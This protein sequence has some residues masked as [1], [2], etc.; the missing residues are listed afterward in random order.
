[1]PDVRV[2]SLPLNPT[3][4]KQN[5]GFDYIEPSV[6]VRILDHAFGKDR[7]SFEIINQWTDAIGDYD[8]MFNVHGRLT[9]YFEALDASELRILVPRTRDYIATTTFR[10]IIS[11]AGQGKLLSEIKHADLGKKDAAGNIWKSTTTDCFKKCAS[12]FGVALE[13]YGKDATAKAF[14]FTFTLSQQNKLKELEERGLKTDALKDELARMAGLG[15]SF[16]DVHPYN[17][18]EFYNYADARLPKKTT[19]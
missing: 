2:L 16:D 19:E 1:M 10:N 8:I 3:A 6:A 5:Q 4:I 15:L 11:G 13:L 14:S 7:W 12:Q 9:V 18:D 17:F